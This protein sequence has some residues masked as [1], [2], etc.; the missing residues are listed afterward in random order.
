MIDP[1]TKAKGWIWKKHVRVV[2]ATAQQNQAT[3]AAKFEPYMAI[4]SADGATIQQRSESGAVSIPVATG[5]KLWVGRLDPSGEWGNVRIPN[6]N[7]IGWILKRQLF[8]APESAEWKAAVARNKTVARLLDTENK[9]AEAL[10]VLREILPT[11][12]KSGPSHPQTAI[13]QSY[14]VWASDRTTA[15]QAV[16][17]A[18]KSLATF[19]SREGPTSANF[20]QAIS[21]TVGQ[22]NRFGE[23][24]LALELLENALQV[25][26]K[27]PDDY[28]LQMRQTIIK[29]HDQY[30]IVENSIGNDAAGQFFA[31]G[32]PF[33]QRLV[34]RSEE[35]KGGTDELTIALTNSRATHEINRRDFESAELQLTQLLETIDR[36]PS[37]DNDSIQQTRSAA[38]ANLGFVY[39]KT[40][41]PEK[42]LE[43]YRESMAFERQRAEGLGSEG[44][45][46]LSHLCR[47]LQKSGAHY[48]AE[49]KTRE[50]VQLLRKGYG[51]SHV[52]VGWRL[53]NLGLLYVEMKELGSAETCLKESSR[54][55]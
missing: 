40:S 6:R 20:R 54:I 42:A 17:Y 10:K 35:L 23:Q 3:S 50:L 39:E 7:A 28:V 51:D 16:D 26:K 2:Q 27:K 30:L 44:V 55:F 19:E 43:L 52:Q 5:T 12:E 9:P 32:T 24:K 37:T 8:K 21:R 45:Q 4:V 15:D 13:A 38:L 34:Q 22:L 29:L 31:R 14:F 46:I 1:R 49:S 11:L 33:F 48:E 47:A 18:K 41:R 25:Q 36:L 53:Q